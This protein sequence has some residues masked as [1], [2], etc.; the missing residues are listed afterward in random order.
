MKPPLAYSTIAEARAWL[1]ERTGQPW[2][3][4]ELLDAASRYRV[5]LHAA[6]PITA[7]AQVMELD[8]DNP[9]ALRVKRRDLGWRMATLS[10]VH[11]GQIMH[12]GVT[13]TI[14]AFGLPVL[15]GEFPFFSEP[16]M[17]TREQVRV[18]ELALFALEELRRK[19]L[20]WQLHST[21]CKGLSA[22]KDLASDALTALE[23]EDP[24][25]KMKALLGLVDVREMLPSTDE[26]HAAG[27][28][29]D[30]SGEAITDRG[31]AGSI[32]GV[33]TTVIKGA[34]KEIWPGDI[35]AAFSKPRGWLREHRVSRGRPGRGRNSLWNPV[36]IAMDLMRGDDSRERVPK[37]RVKA[38]FLHPALVAWQ[39][40]LTEAM[41]E[42]AWY[43][44]S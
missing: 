15:E 41:A 3:E 39:S 40:Q 5:T 24:A 37:V 34:F 6:P 17:V 33:P 4:N 29:I 31:D 26:E 32:N 27:G 2:S 21:D 44:E 12:C 20:R 43:D 35:D 16:V 1:E 22:S 7:S 23:Q 11:I 25:V 38:S 36:G 18:S 19:D 28:S 8:P 30:R 42:D 13:E 14:H 10:P 9:G